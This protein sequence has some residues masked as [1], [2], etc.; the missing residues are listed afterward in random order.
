VGNKESLKAIFSNYLL[1]FILAVTFIYS[2]VYAAQRSFW[3]DE[4]MAA[5]AIVHSSLSPF[6]PLV[7]YN[8]VS[9]W[10]FVLLTRLS[11]S[12]F[13]AGDLQFRLPGLLFYLAGMSYLA[14]FLKQ[15]YGLLTALAITVAILANPL[16]LRYSTEFKHYIYE[17]TFVVL[18]LIS[19]LRWKDGDARSL[20]VYGASIGLSIIFGVSI[21]FIIGAIFIF[22]SFDQFKKSPRNFIKSRWLI[23]HAVYGILFLFWYVFSITPNLKFNLM[24]YP[25]IYG[26]DLGPV[27]LTNLSHW[28]KVLVNTILSIMIP[29]SVLFLICLS[30][31]IINRHWERN[32]SNRVILL[33][34]LLVYLIIYAANFSGYYPIL[35][36]RH[37]LYTLPVFYLLFAYALTHFSMNLDLKWLKAAAPIILI[38]IALIT[39]GIYYF[40]NEFFFQEIKPV[41]EEIQPDDD[42]FVYFAAQPGYEWYK[43]T[44]YQDLPEPINPQI[45]PASGPA[46]PLEEMTADLP[47][48]IKETGAWPT[49]ALLTQLKEAHLYEEEYMGDMIKKEAESLLLISHRSGL[50]LR[51]YLEET[52]GI[53]RIF[54]RPGASVY[55]VNCP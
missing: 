18:I 20:W 47:N 13:G 11:Q 55:Q 40:N 21:V 22:E 30:G 34:P 32:P 46:I 24:N 27:N 31:F 29:Q 25:H 3:I 28:G 35:V 5:L 1:T 19:Y 7:V 15:R 10:G 41:L 26:V 39:S 14:R 36:D 45:N 50:Y 37:L 52:C 43:F 12:L 6:E 8:Q 42:L 54:R 16:L 2:V 9:P 51:N 44:R 17:F 33:L 4:S 23:L 53:S 48:R 38:L 49:I